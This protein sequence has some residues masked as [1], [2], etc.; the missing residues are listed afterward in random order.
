MDTTIDFRANQRKLAVN[1]N[2]TREVIFKLAQFRIALEKAAN[3]AGEDLFSF[4]LGAGY[5]LMDVCEIL[6]LNPEETKT[7]MGKAT[8]QQQKACYR[9]LEDEAAK[10]QELCYYDV[11]DNPL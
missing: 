6:G 3:E 9:D 10:Q 5:V 1:K 2:T 11:D 7:V 8:A 4:T